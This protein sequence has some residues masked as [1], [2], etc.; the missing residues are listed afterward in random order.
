MLVHLL[1]ALAFFGSVL[2]VVLGLGVTLFAL[3]RGNRRLVGQAALATGGFAVLYL[4]GVALSAFLAPRR[5]LPFGKE[6]SFCEFDCHLHLSV[7]GSESEE[8]RVGVFVRVRSDARQ[9]SEYP[10]Y[11]QFRLIGKDDRVV[12]PDNEAR[13]FLRPLEAG[14]SYVDSLYFTVPSDASPYSLRV[15]YPGPIDA[16]LLG[17]A[18]SRALGK[19]T[20]AITGAAP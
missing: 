4:A 5:V 9:A 8:D 1:A 3:A 2:L 15:N 7:V 12:T 14:R 17:P 11:L 19:T 18:N 16:L 13:A 6:L 20:L 10:K